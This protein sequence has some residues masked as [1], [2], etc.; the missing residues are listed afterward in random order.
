M[1]PGCPGGFL[2]LVCI[3]SVI[4]ENV[5]ECYVPQFPQL[6]DRNHKSLNVK[7]NCI[8]KPCQLTTAL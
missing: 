8:R 1:K 5:F 2:A 4:P 6:Y 7:V 3:S